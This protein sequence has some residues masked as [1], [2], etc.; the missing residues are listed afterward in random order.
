MAACLELLALR[1]CF[2]WRQNQGSVKAEH[3]GCKRFFRFASADGIS[4]II[5][6][7]PSGQFLAIECKIAPNKPTNE[8]SK[9]LARVRRNGGVALLIYTID[10]LIAA[11]Q[12]V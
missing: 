9:F 12:E 5:G 7:L 11:L 10:E 4:D 6:V 8:Q 2:A 3:K 1:G